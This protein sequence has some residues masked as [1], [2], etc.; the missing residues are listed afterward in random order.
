MRACKLASTKE[1]IMGR[2]VMRRLPVVRIAAACL[3]SVASSSVN[4]AVNPQSAGSPQSTG[5]QM[6]SDI[7]PRSGMRLSLPNREDLDE[8]GK[9]AYDRGAK[10]GGRK[11]AF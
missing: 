5:P 9:Q 6:P 1:V 2:I 3:L 11:L 4:G 8:T 7:D 10:P